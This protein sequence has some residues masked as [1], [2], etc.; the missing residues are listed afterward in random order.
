[1]RNPL[2]LGANAAGL[3]RVLPPVERILL[4]GA[5]DFA[6]IGTYSTNFG[7][8]AEFAAMLR[9]HGLEAKF[10]KYFSAARRL[11]RA[12]SSRRRWYEMREPVQARVC[13]ERSA[14]RRV[15]RAPMDIVP[16]NVQYAGVTHLVRSRRRRR[17]DHRFANIPHRA[18]IDPAGGREEAA[19]AILM[20]GERRESRA[21]R[22]KARTARGARIGGG[23]ARGK[24]KRDGTERRDKRCSIGHGTHPLEVT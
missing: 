8:A 20:A 7:D 19:A 4:R 5:Q 18:V 2:P 17:L 15:L 12:T 14:R 13:A 22:S 1:M 3:K 6:M 10:P 11:L 21:R 9:S 23:L 16:G 24:D